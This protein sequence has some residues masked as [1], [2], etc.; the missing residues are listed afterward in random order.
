[1][2]AGSTWPRSG[3]RRPARGTSRSWCRR[4]SCRRPPRARGPAPPLLG[5]LQ[6][7]RGVALVVQRDHLDLVAVDA[8]AGVDGLL[9]GRED[10]AVRAVVAGHGPGVGADVA[11]HIG[12][13]A[14]PGGWSPGP[15]RPGQPGPS[16]GPSAVAARPSAP[17]VLVR[18]AIGGPPWCCGAE[19]PGRPWS[20]PAGDGGSPRR[21]PTDRSVGPQWKGNN[22][23]EVTQVLTGIVLPRPTGGGRAGR[24][25]DGQAVDGSRPAGASAR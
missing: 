7:H 10:L 13:F 4:W 11:D 19:S 6:R 24:G 8:A 1:M 15:R 22:R 21:H 25:R 18:L 16:A 9:P 23:H 5:V 2:P 14:G 17:R 12:R 3:A 20:A